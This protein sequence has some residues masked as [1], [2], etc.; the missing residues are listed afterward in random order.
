MSIQFPM[1]SSNHPSV[2][3]SL[4]TQKKIAPTLNLENHPNWVVGS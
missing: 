2:F 3:P 4:D 1:A